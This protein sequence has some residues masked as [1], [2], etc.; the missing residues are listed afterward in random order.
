MQHKLFT[1]A[2]FRPLRLGRLRAHLSPS[3]SH[4]EASEYEQCKWA[5][6]G[7]GG[8]DHDHNA[9]TELRRPHSNL[10]QALC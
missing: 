10:P 7:M 6:D 3:C 9:R 4:R 5:D 2:L 8:A 1:L